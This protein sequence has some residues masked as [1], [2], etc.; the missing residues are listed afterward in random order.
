[1]MVVRNLEKK[2]AAAVARLIPQL[3]KNIFEP[4][5]LAKRI[6]KI[7][8][9]KTSQFFVAEIDGKVVG[10]G[11]LAWYVIPSKGLIGWVEEIVIDEESRG[12][13]IG[14]KL[15]EKILLVAKEKNIKQVKLMSTNPVARKLYEKLGF[16]KK[17]NEYFFKNLV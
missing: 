17:E 9:Q 14:N 1:M 4:G 5:R 2:D 7:T 8:A 13:G 16:Q 3:T 15:L 12:Q 10:F 11:G 6:G